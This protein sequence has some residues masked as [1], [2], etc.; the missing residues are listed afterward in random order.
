MI[1]PYDLFVLTMLQEYIALRLDLKPGCH[2]HCANSLHYYCDEQTVVEAILGHRMR[3]TPKP[4]PVMSRDFP[5]E[6]KLLIGIEI[7]MRS[8]IT[9]SPTD[10]IADLFEGLS[11][12]SGGLLSILAAGARKA[13]GASPQPD[14]PPLPVWC[15]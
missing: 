12:Y 15:E 13:R 5:N 10:S 8:R 6:L 3:I 2:I 14:D 1:M 11:E 9:A 4:M 7:L